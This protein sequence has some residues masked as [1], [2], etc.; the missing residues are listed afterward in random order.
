MILR[1]WRAPVAEADIEAFSAFMEETLYPALADQEAFVSMTTAVD[2]STEPP[3]VVALS[4]WTSMEGLQAF[5]GED[6]EG[7]I[8]EEAERYLA[9]QPQ[10][11]H[12]TVIDR[13]RGEPRP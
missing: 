8:F 2:R 3:H 1:D 12:H 5:T 6:E 4:T 10:V 13:R 11:D 9:G 7:V